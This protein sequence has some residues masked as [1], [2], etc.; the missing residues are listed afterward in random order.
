M[1]RRFTLAHL[2]DVHLGPIA[3][4]SPRH[5]TLKRATGYINW[6]R[7]RRD[8]YRGDVLARLI[9]DLNAQAPDQIAVT[10]DLANIGLPG[11]LDAAAAWLRALGPPERVSVIPGNHDI[12]SPFGADIG[13]ERWADYMAPNAAGLGFAAAGVGPQ[14]YPYVRVF[15]PIALVGLNSAVATPPFIASGRLGHA[16][17]DRLD[18]LLD[19]LH[20]AGLFSV[21]MLH[22]PPLP[23]HPSWFKRL[24]D[25]VEL[26]KILVRRGAGLVIHGHNHRNMEAWRLGPG[27]P[28]PAIGAPSASF[29]RIHAHEPLARYNLYSIALDGDARSI[30]LIGRGLRRPDG[31]L[32]ELDRRRL[33][34]AMPNPGRT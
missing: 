4:F 8:A 19:R 28:F 22:H 6:R 33:V 32:E 15:G 34:P 12:Y 11:E 14:R 18:R 21:L 27:G 13:V 31:G 17:R 3:G 1:S 7:N 30:D 25:A 23:G 24:V 9:D 16:Q 26:E 2:T 29:A 20:T 5:W 10:G